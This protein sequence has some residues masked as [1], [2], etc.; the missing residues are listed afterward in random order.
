MTFGLFVLVKRFVPKGIVDE[1]LSS[2]IYH[3]IIFLCVPQKKVIR[4]GG[5]VHEGE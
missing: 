3:L 2:F 4:F 1:I 5:T